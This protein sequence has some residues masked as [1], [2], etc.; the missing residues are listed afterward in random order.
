MAQVFIIDSLLLFLVIKIYFGYW[1]RTEFSEN[2]LVVIKSR[3]NKKVPFPPPEE[4]HPPKVEESFL[5]YGFFEK[6]CA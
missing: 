2:T 5:N 6:T 1:V 4:K 3:G